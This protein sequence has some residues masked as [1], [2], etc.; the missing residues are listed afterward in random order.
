MMARALEPR[1][2]VYF[3]SSNLEGRARRVRMQET[4]PERG[5]EVG[6]EGGAS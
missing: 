6:E 4:K 5:G 3:I 1:V 2:L